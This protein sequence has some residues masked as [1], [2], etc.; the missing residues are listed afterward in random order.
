MPDSYARHILCVDDDEDTCEL[1]ALALSANRVKLS[2]TLTQGLEL[3][4]REAFDLYILDNWLPDGTGIELCREIRRFDSDTPVLFLSA[5]AYQS[6]HEQ[7]FAAGASAYIDK[8]DGLFGI[9]AAVASLI[10]EAESK[11]IHARI[12]QTSAVAR[13]HS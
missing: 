10:S 4:R 9:E 3:A 12:R 13:R 11:S 6:D 1:L 7:A 5:A 8:P 2:H